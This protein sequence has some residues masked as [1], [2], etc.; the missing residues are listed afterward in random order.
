MRAALKLAGT[1]YWSHSYSFGFTL[2][3]H[4]FL[5]PEKEWEVDLSHLESLIDSKTAAIIVNNPSNP[6]G[7][8]FSAEHILAII[9]GMSACKV[10]AYL[11]FI[12][13]R[14]LR[15]S[16]ISPSSPTKFTRGSFS[17]VKHSTRWPPCPKTFGI[18]LLSF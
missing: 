17:L 14:Q 12:F 4:V 9:A 16:T 13:V 7:S 5:Q 6:C 2:K 11:R 15:R 3:D 8:V 1:N 18:D 10:F